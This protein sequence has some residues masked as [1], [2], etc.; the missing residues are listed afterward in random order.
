MGERGRPKA[1]TVAGSAFRPRRLR[2]DEG[3]REDFVTQPIYQIPNEVRDFAE[4]SVEQAR[5]AF[6]GFA[7]AAQKAIGSVETT[8]TSLQSGAKDVSVKAFG[9]AEANVNAA[10]DLAQ[11]LVQAKDP[12]EV[13]RLQ[14]DFVK[15]QVE[16]IQ[17]QAKE[18]GAALQKATGAKP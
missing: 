14:A 4:K 17:Q 2:F 9:Y 8:T 10:F 15:A 1:R 7:G 13:L 12:Q 16:A 6:E 18:L 3:K 11:K 5:K